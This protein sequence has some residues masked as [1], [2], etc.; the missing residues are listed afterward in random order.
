MLAGRL[1]KK[2][3]ILNPVSTQSTVSGTP[4]ITWS[5]YLSNAWAWVEPVKM[6]D[7]MKSGVNGQALVNK[8]TIRRTTGID[9]N[10]RVVYDGSTYLIQDVVELED[11]VEMTTMRL[12]T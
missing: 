9:V 7:I 3:S 4:T 12:S 6:R 10:M 2:I 11:R 5:T 8:I 1:N